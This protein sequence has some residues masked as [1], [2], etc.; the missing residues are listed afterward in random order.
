MKL[1][2]LYNIAQKPEIWTVE[3]LKGFLIEKTLRF[4]EAIF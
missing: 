1:S 2:D 3:I 4:F